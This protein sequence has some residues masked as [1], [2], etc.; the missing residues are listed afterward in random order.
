MADKTC[1][2]IN[3]LPKH[4]ECLY[5]HLL[6][7]CR[8]K[9]DKSHILVSIAYQISNNR[10]I[11]DPFSASL[12]GLFGGFFLKVNWFAALHNIQQAIQTCVCKMCSCCC[13]LL[14]FLVSTV[15]IAKPIA[16]KIEYLKKIVLPSCPGCMFVC[17]SAC[18]HLLVYWQATQFI[19]SFKQYMRMTLTLPH[20]EQI[21]SRRL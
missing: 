19:C 6:T 11:V 3:Y 17:L 16:T 8:S 14:L 5:L 13:F 4:E 18:F 9:L 20:I 12:M 21:C 7:Q 2:D 15:A 1:I 10:I